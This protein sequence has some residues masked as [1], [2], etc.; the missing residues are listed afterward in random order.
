[1]LLPIFTLALMLMNNNGYFVSS[2]LEFKS[3]QYVGLE[4]SSEEDYYDAKA[5][6]ESATENQPEQEN[7]TQ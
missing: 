4:I 2:I 3:A 5:E 1:L 6:L 7:V